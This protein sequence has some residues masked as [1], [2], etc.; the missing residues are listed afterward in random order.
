MLRD[1]FIFRLC[2]QGIL[3]FADTKFV[4]NIW[5]TYPNSCYRNCN[6]KSTGKFKMHTLVLR[7]WVIN[8][9]MF[10]LDWVLTFI[11]HTVGEKKC[12]YNLEITVAYNYHHHIQS[13]NGHSS[14]I[15]AG[16]V[17][18]K[19]ELKHNIYIFATSFKDLSW[20]KRA[21]VAKGFI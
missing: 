4:R 21:G 15:F 6:L 18:R 11:I 5:R 10:T 7:H 1:L 19:S 12:H 8:N 16:I 14:N 13:V 3:F 9:R 17:T 20:Q 2:S